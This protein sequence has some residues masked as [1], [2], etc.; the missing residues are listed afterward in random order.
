MKVIISQL[1]FLV[2]IAWLAGCAELAKHA[3]TVKPDAQLTATRL[4]NINFEQADLVFDLE[5]ENKNPVAIN[6]AQLDYDLK[7]E[8]HSLLSGVTAQGLQIEPASTT[9]VQL[10]LTLKFDDLRK[11]PGEVWKQD[12]FKYQL[13]TAFVVDL[14]II[15]PYAIPVSKSGELPVPKLPT[16]RLSNIKL[17]S[18]SLLAADVIAQV[19][20]ENP[21]SF[22]IGLS[23]FD[24]RLNVNQQPWGE[25]RAN[26]SNRIPKKGKGSIEVPLKLNFASLGQT[27]YRLLSNRETLEYQ[28]TGGM[29][30][31][32]DFEMLQNYKLP[33]DIQGKANIR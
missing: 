13:D 15:G 21:N 6:L 8:G 26:E 10:P 19:E 5:I 29:I 33:L 2:G 25:G 31:D 9:T 3:E 17:Q 28:L 32:S 20:I 23:D 16:I 18:L 1:L 12:R 14:P 4:A 22:D 24:Y 7:I 30:L 11:L 27:T